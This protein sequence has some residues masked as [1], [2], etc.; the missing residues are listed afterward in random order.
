MS[1]PKIVSDE[2][3]L[4]EDLQ[5]GK[6]SAYK[7]VYEQC[8]NMCYALITQ[9]SG[10]GEDAEDIFQEAMIVLINNLRKPGFEL[11]AK[12]STYLYSVIRKMWLY[13]LRSRKLTVE[14]VDQHS[15]FVD[16]GEDEI[17]EKKEYE[18][19]HQLIKKLLQDL[20]EDCRRLI[21]DYYYKNIKLKD[22]G[23]AMGY[24]DAFVKVKKNR[25]MKGF[26]QLI[27]EHPEFK[28][29]RP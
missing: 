11:K 2:Q 5:A 3:Q 26:M 24:T 6:A 1:K 10:K 20:G 7:Q 13:K 23:V 4:I 9:N 12:V 21:I 27:K 19:K 15:S 17:Q 22:I 8:Y 28:K 18:K 14:L 25:C 16:L 29:L